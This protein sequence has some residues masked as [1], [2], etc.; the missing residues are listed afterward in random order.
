MWTSDIPTLSFLRIYIVCN[1]PFSRYLRR[2]R[3]KR[4]TRNSCKYS[5]D[6]NKL[7]ASFRF[8]C[9]LNG[10][11]PWLNHRYR[12][13]KNSHTFISASSDTLLI[14]QLLSCLKTVS[15]DLCLLVKKSG[16]HM[17]TLRGRLFKSHG[18]QILVSKNIPNDLLKSPILSAKWFSS[19]WTLLIIPNY[20]I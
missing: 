9:F 17:V 16:P 14:M 20:H 10:F 5:V 4:F 15:A 2:L 8:R 18:L 3:L 7:P 1:P 12:R 11:F 19:I 13:I 6:S